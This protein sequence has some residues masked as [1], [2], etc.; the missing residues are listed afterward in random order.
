MEQ[1]LFDQ[2][3]RVEQRHWW[4]TGRLRILDD[5]L[6][7]FV[8]PV[9]GRPLRLIE[10][11]CGTGANLLYFQ[12]K[13]LTVAG[14]DPSELAVEYARK[15]GLDVRQ[16]TFEQSPP[17]D[18]ESFDVALM[19]DVIEHIEDDALCAAAAYQLLRPGGVL[20][21]TT[22]AD[23]AMWSS[24]DEVHRHF[25]RYRRQEL[26]NVLASAG[27]RFQ[28]V[29]HCNTLLYPLAW[30]ERKLLR[31]L[32]GERAADRDPAAILRPPPAPVNALL[33]FIF[34]AER[35][36]LGRIGLPL[37]LSLI[38]VAYKP[39]SNVPHEAD[40]DAPEAAVMPDE[41]PEP[42]STLEAAV[43][44]WALLWTA[45]AQFVN[46]LLKNTTHD[47]TIFAYAGKLVNRGLIP[48][49]DFWDNK[50]PLIF[51]TESLAYRWFGD[52]WLAPTVLQAIFYM[53]TVAC[54]WL[55]ARQ[56]FPSGRAA[57]LAFLILATLLINLPFNVQ[58]ANLTETYQLLPVVLSLLAL[59]PLGVLDNPFRFLASGFFAGIAFL[60]RPTALSLGV[61]TGLTLLLGHIARY[62][63]RRSA[64][65]RFGALW[66]LGAALAVAEP[67]IY[68]LAH[69]TAGGTW[70]AMLGYNMGAYKELVADPPSLLSVERYTMLH[71]QF[72]IASLYLSFAVAGLVAL[73]AWRK[74]RAERQELFPFALALGW[75]G[76]DA[77]LALMTGRP[78]GHYM[79]CLAFSAAFGAAL[80]FDRPRLRAMLGGHPA[81]V[82]IPAA[83]LFLIAA[84]W[85]PLVAMMPD[86]VRQGMRSV[87][88]VTL[89]PDM[90]VARA[91]RKAL[92]PDDKVL[93]LGHPHGHMMHL[94]NPSATTLLSSLHLLSDYGARRWG[95]E[96]LYALEH[97]PSKAV[98]ITDEMFRAYPE[99]VS[100][101]ET[102]EP[103]RLLNR[104]ARLV[105]DRYEPLEVEGATGRQVLIRRN[106]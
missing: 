72:G 99:P 31:P 47:A 69:G 19:P 54:L 93:T 4:F 40:I 43:G 7:R 101:P 5:M 86:A 80:A 97:D 77:G 35:W 60:Y 45:L 91:L 90:Q 3:F 79:L 65:L 58:G 64:T 38:A 102:S 1:T 17:F 92:K 87:G 24:H 46:N 66:A 75:I 13:G 71:R 2:M 11:G 49:R 18:D 98:V 48:Y 61:V 28:F 41:R 55:L 78:Y 39:D 88:T 62:D 33:R 104:I 56:T 8:A 29:S 81:W 50:G 83:G 63:T 20:I 95:P 94:G 68:G 22:P 12:N 85:Q 53:A 105:H 89:T 76:S 9:E 82:V 70:F 16:G 57:R 10:P 25:R 26:V 27:F 106:E 42:V 59:R 52:T 15:R 21:L 36:L 6:R 32:R 84:Q 23:P 37:G 67:T 14:F 30:L 51:V 96:Y 103:A 34:G 44:A 100:Y 74:K 73:I